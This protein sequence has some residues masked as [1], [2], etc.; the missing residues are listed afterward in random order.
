MDFDVPSFSVLHEMML[1]VSVY[2]AMRSLDLFFLSDNDRDV[3][4]YGDW[5]KGALM[6]VVSIICLM[7]SG[8]YTVAALVLL[9]GES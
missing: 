3:V 7:V 2:I 4:R 9:F 8:F 1:I 6:K 5:A